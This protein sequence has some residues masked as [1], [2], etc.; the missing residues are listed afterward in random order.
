MLWHGQGLQPLTHRFSSLSVLPHEH[1]RVLFARRRPP[2]LA[3]SLH[4]HSEHQKQNV[5]HSID[6]LTTG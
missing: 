1:C 4:G 5:L 3:D 6:L 2:E